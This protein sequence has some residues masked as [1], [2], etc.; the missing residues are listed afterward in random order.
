MKVWISWQ[1]I[2]NTETNMKIAIVN[3]NGE[4]KSVWDHTVGN[5]LNQLAGCEG[6]FFDS[7]L[8]NDNTIEIP[9]VNSGIAVQNLILNKDLREKAFDGLGFIKEEKHGGNFLYMLFNGET[10]SDI[11]ELSISTRFMTGGVGPRIPFA[12][13]VGLHTESTT[14]YEAFPSLLRLRDMLHSLEYHGEVLCLI[15][16]DFMIT[17]AIFGHCYWAFGMFSEICKN[18]TQDMLE[19]MFGKLK[20]CELYES[21]CIGNLVSQV[22]YPMNGINCPV[23]HA[24]KGAEK[25]LWRVPRQGGEYLI[26]TCHGAY[27]REA[28]KRIRRTLD[29]LVL[30]N[31]EL[32]FRVDYGLRMSMTLEDK[33]LKELEEQNF[34]TPATSD[35]VVS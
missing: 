33:R 21:I 27:S 26:I 25:H 28:R 16:K 32:Q 6:L 18:T 20:T 23:I 29:N 12:Q 9:M 30:F 17:N 13:G 8:V 22:P 5:E 35:P 7:P 2:S 15:N 14:A 19:F 34:K 10:F 11:M 31:D 1:T 4:N 3:S 24:P